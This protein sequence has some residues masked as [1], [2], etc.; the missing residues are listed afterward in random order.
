VVMRSIPPIRLTVVEVSATSQHG[1]DAGI[2]N[3]PALSALSLTVLTM[4]D[5][6]NPH[7]SAVPRLRRYD[8]IDRHHYL[9][10]CL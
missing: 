2:K 3:D 1:P 7:A 9:G 8:E 10:S 5:R 4:A 6:A